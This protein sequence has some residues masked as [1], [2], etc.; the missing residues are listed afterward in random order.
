M[1]VLVGRVE[2]SDGEQ[3]T[4]AVTYRPRGAPTALDVWKQGGQQRDRLR[5][6]ASEGRQQV[7]FFDGP[8]RRDTTVILPR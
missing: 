6:L 2:V 7:T 8:F 4:I 5:V 3:K 1:T